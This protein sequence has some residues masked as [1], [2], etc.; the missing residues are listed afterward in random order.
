MSGLFSYARP[1]DTRPVA[2]L[3]AELRLAAQARVHR[4]GTVQ[5]LLAARVKKNTCNTHS[6]EWSAINNPSSNKRH[7]AEDDVGGVCNDLTIEDNSGVNSSGSCSRNKARAVGGGNEQYCLPPVR[8]RETQSSSG[9]VT[10]SSPHRGSFNKSQKN[11]ALLVT[12]PSGRGGRRTAAP[13]REEAEPLFG[14]R[15]A[16][17]RSPELPVPTGFAAERRAARNSIGDEKSSR[18]GATSEQGTV[19]RDEGERARLL[20]A[21]RV[22]SLEDP[23]TLGLHRA[24]DPDRNDSP[25]NYRPVVLKSGS[26]VRPTRYRLFLR[27]S[28][29]FARSTVRPR[30]ERDRTRG[31]KPHLGTEARVLEGTSDPGTATRTDMSYSGAGSARLAPTSTSAVL[32]PSPRPWVQDFVSSGDATP[33]GNQDQRRRIKEKA[34]STSQHYYNPGLYEERKRLRNFLKYEVLKSDQARIPDIF[35]PID[36]P[37]CAIVSFADPLQRDQVLREKRKL[38]ENAQLFLPGELETVEVYGKK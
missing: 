27:C 29:N 37:Y 18:A 32:A 13:P 34:P 17:F 10:S 33:D 4:S 6:K 5:R 16:S 1:R 8:H 26:V 12:T 28:R 15:Q 30:A 14:G 19:G 7:L 36:K 22:A 2:Q 9:T 38:F 20:G 31:V 24:D 11:P 35:I 3:G 25:K 23:K 21:A